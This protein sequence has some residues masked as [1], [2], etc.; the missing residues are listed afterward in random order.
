MSFRSWQSWMQHQQQQQQQ[1]VCHALMM[2]IMSAKFKRRN[3]TALPM[4]NAFFVGKTYL[5]LEANLP[6]TRLIAS[7]KMPC[8]AN[9]STPRTH[10]CRLECQSMPDMFVLQVTVNICE[11]WNQ[12]TDSQDCICIVWYWTQFL[13]ADVRIATYLDLSLSLKGALRS[14]NFSSVEFE[15]MGGCT[16]YLSISDR[17]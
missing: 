16:V 4:D 11:Q 2:S 7:A 10:R 5:S 3:T 12:N 9:F 14:S 1:T 15:Q 8:K 17:R 6:S 13:T